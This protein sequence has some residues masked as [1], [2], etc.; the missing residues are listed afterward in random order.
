[1]KTEMFQTRILNISL[2]Q[3]PLLYTWVG[4]FAGFLSSFKNIVGIDDNATSL[5]AP[6]CSR[7]GFC[8]EMRGMRSCRHSLFCT[9]NLNELWPFCFSMKLKKPDGLLNIRKTDAASC[10]VLSSP[11]SHLK[12]PE[13]D[14]WS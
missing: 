12:G 11:I 8:N 6:T 9:G 10:L 2:S 7:G 1:M 4:Y 13:A 5:Q 14:Q 3:G